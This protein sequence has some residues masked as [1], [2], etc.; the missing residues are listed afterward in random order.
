MN[1]PLRRLGF[2]D[3]Y[4]AHASRDELLAEVGLDVDGVVDS[5]TAS[6]EALTE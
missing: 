6:L 5:I 1:T 4:P 2:P 3:F